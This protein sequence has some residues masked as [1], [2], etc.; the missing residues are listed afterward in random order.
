MENQENSKKS[1]VAKNKLEK[2]YSTSLPN[3][4]RFTEFRIGDE[5]NWAYI[6]YSAGVFKDYQLAIR[7]IFKEENTLKGNFKNRCVFLENENGEKK[8]SDY[9]YKKIINLLNSMNINPVLIP[10]NL[11]GTSSI[12]KNPF[13][14]LIKN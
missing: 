8:Y 6:Q 1:S 3:G 10:K 5:N 13:K 2:I 14:T 11:K 9:K 12:I 7:M 4:Y